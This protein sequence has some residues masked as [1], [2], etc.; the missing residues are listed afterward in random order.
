MTDIPGYHKWKTA[1]QALDH[2]K[3]VV[4]GSERLHEATAQDETSTKLLAAVKRVREHYVST[5]N[6][7][8]KEVI[9][10]ASEHAPQ[11]LKE[12]GEKVA[13]LVSERLVDPTALV[14]FCW[15]QPSMWRGQDLDFSYVLRIK[16]GT[17]DRLQFDI[18]L[19]RNGELQAYSLYAGNHPKNE[20]FSTYLAN[21][22]I[23]RLTGWSGLRGESDR[24]AE[25]GKVLDGIGPVLLDV[26]KRYAYEAKS[27]DPLDRRDLCVS[28]GFRQ[29]R[30]ES[31]S[32][33]DR[34][35]RISSVSKKVIESLKIVLGSLVDKVAR[36]DCDYGEKGWYTVTVTVK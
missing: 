5:R 35:D 9:K 19:G 10:Y 36:I 1:T 29:E 21:Q 3:G 25:R 18:A 13:A 17:E 7:A 4:M 8:Q 26:C 20:D 2:M 34:D 28:C 33:G 11:H 23:L 24:N 14:Q 22:V 27:V 30:L 32:E 16:D 15:V 31:L 6:E 12:A